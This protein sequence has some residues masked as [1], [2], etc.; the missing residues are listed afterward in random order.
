VFEVADHPAPIPAVTKGGDS[1]QAEQHSGGSRTPFRAEGEHHR[2]E[3]TLAFLILRELFDFVKT[4]HP[5]PSI[6]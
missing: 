3:A 5:E 1:G 4:N 2:S 6:R